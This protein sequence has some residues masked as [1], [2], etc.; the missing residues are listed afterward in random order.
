M[1]NI[2]QFSSVFGSCFGFD[3]SSYFFNL[4]GKYQKSNVVV[5][6]KSKLPLR[7]RRHPLPI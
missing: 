7:H 2:P 6:R 4:F 3:S 5:F 1:K